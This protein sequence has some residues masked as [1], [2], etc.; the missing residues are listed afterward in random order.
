MSRRSP[1]YYG[2]Q[3][4]GSGL[5]RAFGGLGMGMQNAGQS[6]GRG[7]EQGGRDMRAD[8]KQKEA[9]KKLEAERARQRQLEA[10]KVES[11][12]AYDEDLGQGAG[13]MSPPPGYQRQHVED[14]LRSKYKGLRPEEISMLSGSAELSDRDARRSSALALEKEK[15][16][17][18]YKFNDA[19]MKHSYNMEL[20]LL[21]QEGMKARGGAGGEK[22]VD[23][24]KHLLGYRKAYDNIISKT[25]ADAAIGGYS[26][27]PIETLGN[28]LRVYVDGVRNDPI[29]APE[30][31]AQEVLRVLDNV[32]SFDTPGAKELAQRLRESLMGGGGA[33]PE[34]DAGPVGGANVAGI[35]IPEADIPAVMALA[36]QM[37][38]DGSSQE[39]IAEAVKQHILEA[40]TPADGPTD[41]EKTERLRDETLADFSEGDS[42]PSPWSTLSRAAAG[43]PG[44]GDEDDGDPEGSSAGDDGI[45]G[46]MDGDR[47]AI[48]TGNAAD[49]V[50]QQLQDLAPGEDIPGITA[51]GFSV[52]ATATPAA[53]T[54]RAPP[55]DPRTPEQ[56]AR[57]STAPPVSIGMAPAE[58]IDTQ[59]W[60]ITSRGR[61]PQRNAMVGGSMTSRHQTGNARDIGANDR[62]TPQAAVNELAAKAVEVGRGAS[63][64]RT[65]QIEIPRRFRNQVDP[66]DGV[67]VLWIANTQPNG[68]PTGIHLHVDW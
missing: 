19:D 6:I 35:D 52:P 59:G 55:E 61:S 26:A 60:R 11:Q 1:L 39:E 40:R 13:G 12:L 4:L 45:P 33:A 10:A 9:E 54:P 31:K 43:I 36:E 48:D 7:I 64:V 66:P 65:V 53:P 18:G 58:F 57:P 25:Y 34:G 47:K 38:A 50:R 32:E 37:T 23:A 68:E 41:E 8:M 2:A 63:G 51:P 30:I 17:R 27:L 56:A 29:L 28:K 16:E 62:S 24:N 46:E 14:K 44:G 21:R 20:E 15:R 22:P 42:E 5:E 49:I 3:S 67:K